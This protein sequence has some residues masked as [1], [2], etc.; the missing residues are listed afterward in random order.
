MQLRIQDLL[1]K[2]EGI[3]EYL[4]IKMRVLG[5]SGLAR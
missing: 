3:M 1:K 2:E 5:K 4:L